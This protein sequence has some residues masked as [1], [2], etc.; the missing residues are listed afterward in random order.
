MMHTLR[1]RSRKVERK[2]G[3]RYS[4]ELRRQAVERMNAFGNVVGLA[5]ELAVCRRVL[6]NW[7]DRMDETDPPPSGFARW[8]TVR[9]LRKYRKIPVATAFR[10][11]LT[12]P[13]A[14]NLGTQSLERRPD[15]QETAFWRFSS[16]VGPPRKI[17]RRHAQIQ[18]FLGFSDRKAT[19]EGHGLAFSLGLTCFWG[20]S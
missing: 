15:A 4:N 12:R 18:R 3:Q 14:G 10:R 17:S 16:V 11:P 2:K 20:S 1:E 7:R 9:R 13:A 5:K 6:Y 19:D 8:G